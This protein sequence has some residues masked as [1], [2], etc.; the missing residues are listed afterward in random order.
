MNN[1]CKLYYQSAIDLGLHPVEKLKEIDGFV[2]TLGK[3]NY[4]F[5]GGLT[6]F[7]VISSSS[8][9]TNKYSTNKILQEAGIPVPDVTGITYKEYQNGNWSLKDIKFPVVAKPA[10]DTACG[11]NV[12]CNIQDRGSLI[13]YI[14]KYLK[15]IRCVSI[16]EYQAG[17]RSY[18]VLIFCGEVIGIV[19]RIPAHVVGDGSS[20]IRAL[21]KIKNKIRQDLKKTIPTGPITLNEETWSIFRELNLTVNSIPKAGE[22]VPLRYICNSTYGGSFISLETNVICEENARLASRAAQALDLGLVGFDVIC[23]DISIPIE[24]SRGFFIEANVDPDITIHESSM[25][26]VPNRVS[27]IILKRLIFKHP[28]LYLL[29]QIEYYKYLSL[30][31]RLSGVI[32]VFGIFLLGIQYYT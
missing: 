14:D 24:A 11:F 6:P 27:K 32:A 3:N 17:L 9:G 15:H 21:I 1:I 2:I 16:E 25:D 12:L 23:E 8:I 30:A 28:F 29:K 19:E 7:N 22:V 4:Y 31:L 13:K 18:R 10:W 20:T 26:G 5:R